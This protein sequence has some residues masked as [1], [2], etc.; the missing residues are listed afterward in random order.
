MPAP[1][2]PRR[3]EDFIFYYYAKLVIA[4]S[5][6]FNK[7]YRFIVDAYKRLKAGEIRMSDYDRELQHLAQQTDSCAYCGSGG[8]N[9]V[10]SEVVPKSMG[11]PIGIH[12]LVM[13]CPSCDKTKEGKD[14]VYWW[15]EIRKRHHDTL[16]RVP[17]GLYLKLA[18]ELHSVNFTLKEKCTDLGQLFISPQKKCNPTPTSTR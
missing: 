4:P 15:R 2:V 11:G 5:S 8:S 6:G 14:L 9:L 16:P 3:V 10:P 13:A 12:N 17:A 18:F 1:F 7:N